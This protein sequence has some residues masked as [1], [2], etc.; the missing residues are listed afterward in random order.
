MGVSAD[1]GTIGAN[2]GAVKNFDFALAQPRDLVLVIST[3]EYPCMLKATIG[4]S[5]VITVLA[6]NLNYYSVALNI[7]LDFYILKNHRAEV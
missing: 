1:F 3:N 7:T 5:G 4:G 2:A 6:Y